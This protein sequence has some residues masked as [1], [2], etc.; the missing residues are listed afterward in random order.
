MEEEEYYN[1]YKLLFEDYLN[2]TSKKKEK[3]AKQKAQQIFDDLNDDKK[4]RQEFDKLVRLE[5]LKNL[6]NERLV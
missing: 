1:K 6:N 4:V 3:T 2:H 5:K